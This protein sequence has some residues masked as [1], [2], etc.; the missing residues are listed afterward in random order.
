VDA[1]RVG[2][3]GSGVAHCAQPN[4]KTGTY[5]SWDTLLAGKA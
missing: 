1:G 5:P 4:P 2:A 3:V